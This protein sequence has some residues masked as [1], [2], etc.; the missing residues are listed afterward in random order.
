MSGQ[1]GIFADEP[2]KFGWLSL[3]SDNSAAVSRTLVS[4]LAG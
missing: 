2:A 3:A 1:P 4:E